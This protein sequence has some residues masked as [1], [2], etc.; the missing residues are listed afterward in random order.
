MIVLLGI[1]FSLELRTA[2]TLMSYSLIYGV[3]NL[4]LFLGVS[5]FFVVRIES[6]RPSIFEL[7]ADSLM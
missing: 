7:L 2:T 4:D 1:C 5:S 3:T 6:L